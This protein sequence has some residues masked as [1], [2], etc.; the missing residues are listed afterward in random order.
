MTSPAPDIVKDAGETH[1]VLV[2]LPLV[3]CHPTHRVGLGQH[4]G[5]AVRHHHV[6]VGCTHG[7]TRGKPWQQA[8]TGSE[9]FTV[10]IKASASSADHELSKRKCHIELLLI[11]R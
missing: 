9:Y 6:G 2:G 3:R 11:G 10:V 7:K 4:K 8:Y 1:P 5:L